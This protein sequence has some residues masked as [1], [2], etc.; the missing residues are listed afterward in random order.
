[1]RKLMSDYG[2]PACCIALVVVWVAII[3][4]AVG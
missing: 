3:V 1:M 2:A 4:K